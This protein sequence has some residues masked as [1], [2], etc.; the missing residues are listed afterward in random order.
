MPPLDP[1]VADLLPSEP[2]L[3]AYDEQLSVTYLRDRNEVD[4]LPEQQNQRN[5]DMARNR[6]SI[7]DAEVVG[8]LQKRLLQLPQP[9]PPPPV[10]NKQNPGSCAQR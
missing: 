8:F 3:S 2:A 1:D 5:D 4:P 10:N 6:K 9:G 7:A